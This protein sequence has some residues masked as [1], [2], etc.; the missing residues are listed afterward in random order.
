MNENLTN[1]NLEQLEEVTE[2]ATRSGKPKVGA[3][4]LA[5][6][7]IVG[8]GALVVKGVKAIT[9]KVKAKKAAKQAENVEVEEIVESTNE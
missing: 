4:I 9:K 8:V 1:T 5:T 7:A 2:E 3:V 6:A